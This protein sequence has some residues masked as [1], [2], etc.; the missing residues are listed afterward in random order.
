[1]GDGEE[2]TP[3][4]IDLAILNPFIKIGGK[5]R[6]FLPDHT[7][8]EMPARLF[9][10]PL[11]LLSAAA[12]AQKAGISFVFVDAGSKM[13]REERA[14]AAIAALKP[15]WLLMPIGLTGLVESARFGASVK[16]A[17]PNTRICASGLMPAAFPSRLI[18]DHGFDAVLMGELE[19]PIVRLAREGKGPNIASRDPENNMRVNLGERILLDDLDSL[20]MPLYELIEAKRYAVPFA[21]RLPLTCVQLSRGCP[22][23]QCRFCMSNL[24]TLNKLRTMSV[25]RSMEILAALRKKFGYR[26]IFFRDQVFTADRQRVASLCGRMISQKLDLTWRCMT[27]PDS[28][29]QPMLNLMA[30][31]GCYQISFGF[32]SN[33]QGVLDRCA[34]GISLEQ[35][36]NA[37]RMTRKTGIEVVGNFM[38]GVPGDTPENLAGLA[39]YASKTLEVDLAQFNIMELD[40]IYRKYLE[41]EYSQGRSIREM[42]RP[43][44]FTMPFDEL[45]RIRAGLNRSFYLRPSLWFKWLPRVLSPSRWRSTLRTVASLLFD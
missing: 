30:R 37:A 25:D 38:L 18:L 17:S 43:D 26:E 45:V 16:K 41:M 19:E 4:L 21:K 13:L 36:L 2:G 31:A 10:P 12:S 42:T 28:V 5:Y 33:S 35:N 9:L 39:E 22:H 1:M 40:P 6:H 14:I 7:S 44:E 34:K 24:W 15:A 11:E 29:D 8:S 27:R 32:E 3:D 20:P 23:S